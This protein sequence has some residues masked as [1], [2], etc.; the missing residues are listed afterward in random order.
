MESFTY[1]WSQDDITKDI[2]TV[3]TTINDVIFADII[4]ISFSITKEMYPLGLGKRNLRGIAGTI[5]FNKIDKDVTYKYADSKYPDIV[6]CFDIHIK[7]NDKLTIL[8][9][10]CELIDEGLGIKID[11][12]DYNKCDNLDI[13]E[14]TFVARKIINYEI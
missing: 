11:D 6:P 14:H 5:I 7:N 2:I 3:N 8:L 10:G 1:N 9:Q 13:I 4:G 12:V